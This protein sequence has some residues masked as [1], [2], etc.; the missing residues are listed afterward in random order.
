MGPMAVYS[1]LSSLPALAL[2]V[3]QPAAC[4]NIT[5]SS[6]STSGAGC[7]SNTARTTLSNKNQN[8]L[9]TLSGLNKP[10]AVCNIKIDISYPVVNDDRCSLHG[11]WTIVRKGTSSGGGANLYFPMEVS[12]ANHTWGSPGASQ[13]STATANS[14]VGGYDYALEGPAAQSNTWS[15]SD[16][17]TFTFSSAANSLDQS[18]PVGTVGPDAVAEPKGWPTAGRKAGRPNKRQ[19][20]AASESGAPEEILEYNP[21]VLPKGIAQMSIEEELASIS[22]GL[23]SSVLWGKRQAASQAPPI[24]ASGK[25]T[26]QM[27]IEL[28]VPENA[29]DATVAS[30]EISFKTG[31][32]DN[33]LF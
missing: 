10:A 2:A 11:L 19:V 3:N 23:G 26:G 9:I 28:G 1:I 18:A 30:I 17:N 5:V 8:A 25:A 16:S 12:F 29:R 32:D 31:I 7:A 22:H 4:A 24:K 20:V 21:A 15:A 33:T 27:N 13:I 6:V 14:F